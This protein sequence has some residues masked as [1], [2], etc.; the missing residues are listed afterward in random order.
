LEVRVPKKVLI[1]EDDKKIS[2][3]LGVRLRANGY[4]VLQAFDGLQ[5]FVQATKQRPDVVVLDLSMPAGGGLSVAARM[6]DMID[7]AAVPIIFMTA[8]KRPDLIEEA[9]KYGAIGLLEKPFDADLLLGLI[10]QATGEA[11]AW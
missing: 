11:D 10:R 6:R 4:E 1:V 2:L 9:K 5:G 3:A 7:L 8:S